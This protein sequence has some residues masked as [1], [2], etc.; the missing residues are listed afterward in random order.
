LSASALEAAELAAQEAALVR[1]WDAVGAAMAGVK[2]LQPACMAAAIRQRQE[3]SKADG[4][5]V[6]PWNRSSLT[7]IY[8]CHTCSCHEILR[9]R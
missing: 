8:L 2:D 6:S 7:E 5:A 3:R 4:E 9:R 1:R